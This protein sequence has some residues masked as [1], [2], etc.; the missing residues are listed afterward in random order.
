MEKGRM[1]SVS[2]QKTC[3]FSSSLPPRSCPK[4]PVCHETM[5]LYLLDLLNTWKIVGS[6]E[7]LLGSILNQLKVG[8]SSPP[9]FGQDNHSKTDD[10]W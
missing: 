5:L 10:K 4:T 3:V 6:Q 7:H 8:K 2:T 9:F 1:L